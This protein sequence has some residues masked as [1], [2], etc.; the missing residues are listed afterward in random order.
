M[1]HFLFRLLSE[2]GCSI[3]EA[4]ELI[5]TADRQPFLL[6]DRVDCLIPVLFASSRWERRTALDMDRSEFLAV[7]VVLVLLSCFVGVLFESVLFFGRSVGD[8][9]GD[10]GEVDWEEDLV[11]SLISTRRHSSSFSSSSSSV[12][13]SS[14]HKLMTPFVSVVPLLTFGST[15]GRL[16]L[17]LVVIAGS[18]LATSGSVLS[19]FTS[20]LPVVVPLEAVVVFSS[21]WWPIP[22]IVASFFSVLNTDSSD[23]GGFCE[24][25]R[26]AEFLIALSDMIR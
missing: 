23:D 2:I 25:S 18:I 8:V 20:L 1:E 4:R 24:G 21:C 13:S 16:R 17:G 9:D 5:F 6:K 12:L 14:L 22:T 26:G 3:V 19:S 7:L 11:L 15:A 10:G